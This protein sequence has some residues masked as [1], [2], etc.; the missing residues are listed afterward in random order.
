[1]F[2]PKPYIRDPK[3]AGTAADWVKSAPVFCRKTSMD[4]G[5]HY[6][7]VAFIPEAPPAGQGYA[8][9]PWI[10]G[11]WSPALKRGYVVP[12]T[13]Q[14][15]TAPSLRVYTGPTWGILQYR[16]LEHVGAATDLQC[17]VWMAADRYS[18]SREWD[19]ERYT[20][21]DLV[22]PLF[23]DMGVP[24]GTP[25][26]DLVRVGAL[27]DLVRVGRGDVDPREAEPSPPSPH[28]LHG[29]LQDTAQDLRMS[30]RDGCIIGPKD[31][32]RAAV[33]H[34]L[35]SV[36]VPGEPVYS[37]TYDD[38][39]A[40]AKLAVRMSVGRDDLAAI[41]VSPQG[42]LLDEELMSADQYEGSSRFWIN[43]TETGQIAKLSEAER[44]ALI[45]WANSSAL[46]TMFVFIQYPA[47]FAKLLQGSLD[48]FEGCDLT[49]EEARSSGANGCYIASDLDWWKAL[50]TPETQGGRKLAA[51]FKNL[52][53]A[54]RDHRDKAAFDQSLAA[55]ELGVV[56]DIYARTTA[57]VKKMQDMG[58]TV[59]AELLKKARDQAKM[60][61]YLQTYA[62]TSET[63][64]EA[65]IGQ[66]DYPK[67]E[68]G[69]F[70]SDAPAIQNMPYV[71]LTVGNGSDS[72]QAHP[73][74]ENTMSTPSIL[75][76]YLNTV[77]DAATTGMKAGA[78]TGTTSLLRSMVL[79]RLGK[80]T[81]WWAKTEM[82]GSMLD[83]FIPVGVLGGTY[84]LGDRVPKVE[85]V[86]AAC[87]YAIQGAVTVNAAAWI[88]E[89]QPL[90]DILAAEGER[91]LL[92]TQEDATAEK[93][94]T[95]MGEKVA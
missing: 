58:M 27:G 82:F 15:T 13:V 81:P 38:D 72:T 80:R 6:Y 25:L 66:W 2:D 22:R 78:A 35:E 52:V 34:W 93:V 95:A 11:W 84:I 83:F 33:E 49:K 92:N 69:R 44:G 26:P 70:L 65:V 14:A 29:K 57:E 17:K 67:T 43:E 73:N 94:K 7:P 79:A 54:S 74:K 16:D 41:Y 76:Q 30:M 3:T 21:V 62:A 40:T 64:R 36:D 4:Q 37:I 42:Y 1:M 20:R 53:A 46:R 77:R 39:R 5:E 61:L 9:S 8:A 91:L 75:D 45:N 71:D 60:L 59:D 31:R 55:P 89:L 28:P 88:R 63:I 51:E 85:A 56:G 86:R 47:N 87:K 18:Y 32:V 12:P 68:M 48:V 10:A 23:R 90:L 24:L 19:S 50:R